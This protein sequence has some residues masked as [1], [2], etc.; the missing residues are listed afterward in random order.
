MREV[1][2][3]EFILTPCYA[4]AEYHG[5]SQGILSSGHYVA[6]VHSEVVDVL[7]IVG[8]YGYPAG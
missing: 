4:G 6:H 2:R 3:W 1:L 8:K 7:R 5:T